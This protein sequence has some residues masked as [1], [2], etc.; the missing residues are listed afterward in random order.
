MKFMLTIITV[1][2]MVAICTYAN[3]QHESYPDTQ[4]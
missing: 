1:I 4:K 3:D 2:A